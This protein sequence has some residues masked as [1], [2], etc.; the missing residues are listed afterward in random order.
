MPPTPPT[1]DLVV[2]GARIWTLD[3]ERPW[4]EALAVR[5]GVLVAVGPA[6]EVTRHAGPGT[7]VHDL[8]GALVLPGL[9]DG[10]VHL[11]LAGAQAAFELP[12]LPTDTLDEVLAKVRAWAREL[13]PDAWVVGGILGSTV[14]GELTDEQHRLALDE[15]SGGR[16]VLIRDDTMHNRWV[17]SR[18]LELMGVGHDTP[19]EEGGRFVRDAGGRL[20]GVLHELASARAESAFAASIAD[21]TARIREAVA[22]AVR[23]LN[24]YGITSAQEAAT[25]GAPLA[26]LRD[27][28]ARG[29]LTL[30]VV[31][32]LPV[33]PF[34]EEGPVGAELI[35]DARTQ[36]SDLVRPDFVKIVLDGVPMTRTTAL[37][38]PYLC[39][40]GE[41]AT[42]GELYFTLADLVAEVERCHDLGLGA[43][44]HATGDASVRLVLDAVEQVR[45][46]RGD[47]PRFQIAHTEY[48]HPD[49]LPRFAALG[50]VA[51]ASP[52]LW[53]P[54][55][56]QDSI[57]VHVPEDVVA[58]SWPFR[59]LVDSGALVA[60]GSDWPCAA[61]TPDPWTGL[62]AMVTRRNP[63][64]AV[65]GALNPAQAL[66]VQEAVTAF[67]AH[68]AEALGLGDVT[69][70]LTPGRAADF[71]VV[72]RDLFAVEPEQVHRTRV[73]RTYFAG[74][75]VYTAEPAG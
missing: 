23:V 63:D 65:P 51:D 28:E 42:T 55:V 66:T 62:E 35:D 70:R 7:E 40:H 39:R 52:H 68:P 11:N 41:P 12:L 74:R 16:P 25:M 43:K 72:D 20:T 34:L 17:S 5:D 75:V 61:P 67:T 24:S 47:G 21:P 45:S 10:H 9:V 19:D 58:A 15:A 37:L 4:A 8:A 59:D 29:E 53:F 30:R 18:A 13:P 32:S 49:D 73:L 57:A 71:V 27:L 2:T 54:G 36:R 60:A 69:G 3:P 48:V 46:R 14:L 64:P 22:T 33:R 56:I 31:A 38:E 44:F 1:P 50:V 6:D 26:A